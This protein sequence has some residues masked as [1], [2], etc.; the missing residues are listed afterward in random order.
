LVAAA[1]T[2]ALYLEVL[3]IRRIRLDIAMILGIVLGAGVLTKTNAFLSVYLIPTTAI[4]F[5]FKSKDRVARFLRWCGFAL[6]AVVMAYAIYSVLRL[7]PYFNI[8]EDKNAT[9]VYPF[10]EWIGHPFRFFLGNLN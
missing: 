9:F 8:I 4:L 1:A 10:S 2:W 6:V 5:N 3:L 7:S